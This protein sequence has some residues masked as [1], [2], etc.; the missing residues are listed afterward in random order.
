[1]AE[2]TSQSKVQYYRQECEHNPVNDW[3]MEEDKNYLY[4]SV[5][6]K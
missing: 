3:Q 2:K 1:M 5:R 6:P 4:N